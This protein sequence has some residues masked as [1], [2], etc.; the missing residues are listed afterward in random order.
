MNLYESIKNGSKI[1]KESS[2]IK[3]TDAYDENGK[4]TTGVCFYVDDSVNKAIP[5]IEDGKLDIQAPRF[6][7]DK[8]GKPY[9]DSLTFYRE[10]SPE[11]I[12]EMTK[13]IEAA[14]KDYIPVQQTNSDFAEIKEAGA[15]LDI[16][17]GIDI[18][19][20]LASTAGMA[21]LAASEEPHEKTDTKGNKIIEIGNRRD[22]VIGL[23]ERPG[24]Y[25][26]FVVAVNYDEESGSWGYGYYFSNKE[27]AKSR[28]DH[29]CKGG[30][31]HDFDEADEVE[32]PT[33]EKEVDPKI[34]EGNKLFGKLADE[35]ESA[36][37]G[38]NGK[39]EFSKPTGEVKFNRSD[40]AYIDG[41]TYRLSFAN[42]H[43]NFVCEY[44]SMSS[45]AELNFEQNGASYG[46]DVSTCFTVEDA[47]NLVKA[48]EI[49]W[50]L[51]SK[52][53]GEIKAA[54]IPVKIRK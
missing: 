24:D 7:K 12:E 53:E 43:F 28:F 46:S 9:G 32:E 34:V 23:L 42:S 47:K 3:T 44:Y 39:F 17:A 38:F 29:L 15:N 54:G 35:V 50:N 31:M 30:N 26:P 33:E 8:S 6:I 37:S 27:I 21:L 25:E 5:A 45:S 1:I 11:E 13:K 49:A 20:D 40:E 41:F 16:S 22:E 14:A 36:F 19:D 52:F 2:F 4:I 51:I 18:P 48:T 10:M